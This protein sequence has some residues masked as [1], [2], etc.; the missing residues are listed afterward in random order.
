MIFIQQNIFNWYPGHMAKTK[1][2][3]K[4]N[5]FLIDLVIEIVYARIT[6]IIKNHKIDKLIDGKKKI[7]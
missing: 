7:M 1:K 5:L 3:L 4:E 6:L 2:N